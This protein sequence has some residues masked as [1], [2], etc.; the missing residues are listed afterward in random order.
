MSKA[1][2]KA[3]QYARPKACNHWETNCAERP[4]FQAVNVPDTMHTIAPDMRAADTTGRNFCGICMYGPPD[5]FKVLDKVD[6]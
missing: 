3:T 5:L 2:G 1:V 4:R 6:T